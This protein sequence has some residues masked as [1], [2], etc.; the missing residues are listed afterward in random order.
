MTILNTT[1]L[2]V[3]RFGYSM[4]ALALVNIC[5]L[6]LLAQDD[7]AHA[8]SHQT[9]EQLSQ[10]GAL[11]KIVRDSTARFKDVTVAQAEGYAL[12]FGCVSGDDF[13]AMGLHYLN[14]NILNSGALDAPGRRS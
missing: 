8:A 4:I 9:P 14:G 1:T 10:A 2:S 12:T 5:P 13:G 11:I 3:R 6:R 7:H